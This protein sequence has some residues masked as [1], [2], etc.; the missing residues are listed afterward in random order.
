MGH[1]ISW[2]RKPQF[3]EGTHSQ[4]CFLGSLDGRLCQHP[5]IYNQ[6]IASGQ[7][8]KQFISFRTY[9]HGFMCATILHKEYGMLSPW[10]SIGGYTLAGI[11]GITRQ[12][13]NRH[14]IGDVLVGAGI[15]MI[16]TDLGYF[17]SDLIFTRMLPE[18]GQHTIQPLRC[19]FIPEPQHGICHRT[20]YPAYCRTI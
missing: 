1:E 12:L 2:S 17:F 3:M 5:E 20:F 11:T 14:W 7:F 19:T 16:S 4:Q 9:S 13:N 15:G 18:R 6:R 8:I 10:Y